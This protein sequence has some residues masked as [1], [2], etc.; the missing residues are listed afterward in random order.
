MGLA[1]PDLEVLDAD[2]SGF[3]CGQRTDSSGGFSLD[4]YLAE[5]VRLR[6]EI[7]HRDHWIGDDGSGSGAEIRLVPGEETRAPD[8][9]LGGI[10]LRLSEPG[11]RRG[12]SGAVSIRDRLGEGVFGQGY[13]ISSDLLPIATLPPG[14]YSLRI[15]PNPGE[16][17]LPQWYDGADSL[18]GATLLTIPAD[19]GAIPVDLR[20]VKG[21]EIRGRALDAAGDP[22]RGGFVFVT[23]TG[24]D[25]C[26]Y[27]ASGLDEEG[28]FAVVGLP[29]GEYRLGLCTDVLYYPDPPFPPPDPT[30]W[31]PTGSDWS[32]AAVIPIRDHAVVSGI[33]IRLS[34]RATR[35]GREQAGI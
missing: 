11:T 9:V 6:C 8:V 29:D 24:D 17:W 21:G 7:D 34:E 27:L 28:N 5:R 1:P 35:P 26:R 3:L 2:D 25:L 14:E 4:V 15:E 30:S 22:F 18:S 19:G 16:D 33:E 23:T 12:W 10:L 32:Q 20:L 13:E 31:Y